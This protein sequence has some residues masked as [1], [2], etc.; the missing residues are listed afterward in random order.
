MVQMLRGAMA[1]AI[2]GMVYYLVTFGMA[3]SSGYPS[4]SNV[5]IVIGVILYSNASRL[6]AREAQVS[7]HTLSYLSCLSCFVASV[8]FLA[9]LAYTTL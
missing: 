5:L 6:A 2:L 4:F 8:C 9:T 7:P 3:A 1:W